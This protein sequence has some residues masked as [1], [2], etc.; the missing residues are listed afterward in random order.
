MTTL[1]GALLIG[2]TL[3]LLGSG[4]SA[5]TV[6]ILVYLIGHDAKV[7]IAESMAIVGAISFVGAIPKAFAKH[8]DWKSVIWFGIPAMAG[9][10]IGAWLGGLSSDA[11]QLTVF[12]VVVILAAIL[13]L[14]KAF[15]KSAIEDL[16]GE[17]GNRRPFNLLCVTKITF[18][19]VLVGIL[20]GFVGVGGGFLI[21]PALL[22]LEKLPIKTA[23]G[24]SLVIIA[25]KSA[26]G[27]GKYQF[28]LAQ[29]GL[30]VDL[31]T[32]VAFVLIGVAGCAIGQKLNTSMN[33]QSLKRVF[34]IFLVLIG[35]FVI[36]REGG[37]LWERPINKPSTSIQQTS[38]E[39]QLNLRF[40]F[41]QTI[42][43][44]QVSLRPSNG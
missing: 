30:S 19:G 22:M 34:A 18:E 10:Y 40:D 15:G 25:L 23:I 20:T 43:D 16:A 13:M 1:I 21:V 44:D 12:G 2:A 6:P 38:T 35:A 28:I 24:T 8:V 26:I 17:A 41:N 33:Q 14:R 32:I 27:F 11:L 39:P 5:I 3:G 37:K 36:I 42:Q 31:Q 29:Q 4:G 7:S 9:T